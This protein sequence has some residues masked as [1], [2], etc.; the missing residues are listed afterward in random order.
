MT[1]DYKKEDVVRCYCLRTREGNMH[2][3]LTT[4]REDLERTFNY[5]VRGE[6]IIWV[7]IDKSFV[8]TDKRSRHCVNCPFK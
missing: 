7:D 5:Q 3:P 6:E 2:C 4:E 8:C 1:K